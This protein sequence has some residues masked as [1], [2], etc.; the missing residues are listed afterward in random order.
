MTIN[1]DQAST[2]F[3]VDGITFDI[4][5]MAS[6]MDA[7]VSPDFAKNLDDLGGIAVMNLEGI[8]TRYT[9]PDT[10]LQ[11]IISA[12]KTEATTI[13]QKAYTCLLYT[14]PSPRDS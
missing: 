5:I 11:E 7:V 13:L 2:E 12:S 3:S 6:A 14:S 10:I 9:D 4:P 8:Q 1:P